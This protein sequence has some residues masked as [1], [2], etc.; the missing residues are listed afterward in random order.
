MVNGMA[1]TKITITVPDSQ[2]AEIKK[3][4][5][6][7]EA[8]SI[9]GFVQRAVQ[10]SLENEAEFRAMIDEGLAATGGPLTARERTWARKMLTSQKPR[11]GMRNSA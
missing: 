7:R 5:M 6:A 2:L 4:V 8:S 3:R 1:T 10:K 9:S 11:S